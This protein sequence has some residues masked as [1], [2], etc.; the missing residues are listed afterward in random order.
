MVDQTRPGH[1]TATVVQGA[2]PSN[3]DDPKADMSTLGGKVP[4]TNSG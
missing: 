3:D 4:V 1:D 2:Q